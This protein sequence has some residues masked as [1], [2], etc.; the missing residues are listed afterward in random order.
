MALN[1]EKWKHNT[2][3]F[4]R[5][6]AVIYF[7]AVAVGISADGFSLNDFVPDNVVVGAMVL[8][9]INVIMDFFKKYN[10]AA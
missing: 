8:Y 4:L 5:P 3:Y 7:G 1:W 10:A 9:V 6:L 2:L